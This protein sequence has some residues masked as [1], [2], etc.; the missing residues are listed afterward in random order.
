MYSAQNVRFF[1]IRVRGMGLY[2][3]FIILGYKQ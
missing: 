3:I 1:T 2:I